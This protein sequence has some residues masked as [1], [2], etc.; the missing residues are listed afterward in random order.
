M[1]ELTVVLVIPLGI[2]LTWIR[3]VRDRAQVTQRA[4]LASKDVRQLQEQA[5]RDHSTVLYILEFYIFIY[6]FEYVVMNDRQSLNVCTALCTT[7][8]Y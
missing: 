5:E 6:E 1:E 4:L 3:E 8:Q 7:Y 2:A